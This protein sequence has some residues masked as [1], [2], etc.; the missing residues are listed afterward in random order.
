MAKAVDLTGMTFGR[1][2]GV[3][4]TGTDN[5]GKAIWLFSC[6]CGGQVYACPS[7]V[8][9]GTTSSCGC[10]KQET[11]RKNG[12]LGGKEPKHGES[13]ESSTSEYATWKTMR[14]R[15]NN[16]NCEDY[17]AYGGRGIKVCERWNDY[18]NFIADMGRK[19]S[20]KH[21]IDRIDNNGDY[22]PSN[23]KWSTNTEQ[24]NNRRKRGTG[25]KSQ[26]VR[27]NGNIS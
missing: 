17:P 11:A 22:S 18:E 19:P 4:R 16:K 10:L 7:L 2:T 1:L 8:K 24:A 25:E 5:H 12:L 14:Q 26:K 13:G 6:L 27:T 21:S 3:K 23:C 15:C 20:A 9:R